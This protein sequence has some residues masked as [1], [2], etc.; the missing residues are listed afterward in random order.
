VKF[1]YTGP[2]DSVDV[3]GATVAPGDTFDGPADLA[4]QPDNFTP[5]KAATTKKES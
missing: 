2:H 3:A 5:V 1:T 4:N